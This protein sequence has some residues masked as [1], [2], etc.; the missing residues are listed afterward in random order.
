[1]SN[2]NVFAAVCKTKLF[3]IF[4][5]WY[6]YLTLNGTCGFDSGSFTPLGAHSGFLL[7]LMAIIDDLLR[8][9]GIVAVGYIIYGGFRYTTSQ[10]SPDQ[11]AGAQKTIINAVIGLVLSI[12][13][14]TI[15][16]FIGKRLG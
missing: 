9:A 14:V 8:L 1:M 7:I 13:A 6:Q 2:L 16:S 3:G 4:V 5:P 15:V 12:F 10:G 11:T